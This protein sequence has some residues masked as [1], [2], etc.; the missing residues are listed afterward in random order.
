MANLLRSGYKML[1][2]SCPICNNPIFKKKNGE[3]FCPVCD[4]PVILDDNELNESM[5]SDKNLENENNVFGRLFDDN[6]T[7]INLKKIIFLKI[8]EISEIIKTENQIL[9]IEVY[10]NLLQ[11]LLDL[12]ERI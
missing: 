11:K 4:R 1:N 12:Y 3:M 8:Q 7:L 9:N 5:K 6:K 10:I 2:L